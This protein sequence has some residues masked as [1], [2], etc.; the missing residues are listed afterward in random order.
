MLRV[1]LLA[2]AHGD[3]IWIEYGDPPKPRRVLIDGGPASTYERGLRNRIEKAAAE[4]SG[5][6][7]FE[8][9]II[10]HIDADHIDVPLIFLRDPGVKCTFRDI[11][12]NG[13]QQ[14]APKDDPNIFA[15][16]QGEFLASIL[17]DRAKKLPWNRET[18][19]TA[20]GAPP[21]PGKLRTVELAGGLKL[22]LL[23]P[24]ERE[25]QRLRSRWESAIRD[26]T[27]GDMEEARRRLEDRRDY[28]P[29]DLPPVFAGRTHGNDRTPANGSS[30]VVL[31]EMGG[32]AVLLTGDAHARVLAEGLR[33]LAA[34]RGVPAIRLDA[35]KLPHHGSMGN[36][37]S[38]V[39]DAVTCS[40]FLFSTNGAIFEHPDRETVDLI[41]QKAS[42]PVEFHFN[43]RS[44]TTLRFEN[45]EHGQFTSFYGDGNITLELNTE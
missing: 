1:E 23:A 42:G 4:G 38:E 2:A 45:D 28:R 13:W 11:W 3:G 43:Y 27:P 35:F 34:E 26:F 17:G 12:F 25:L 29:P 7:A 5:S 44:P 31:A 16:L 18:E 32:C 36:L 19:S 30:I 39:L 22:T 6:L 15:P 41:L 37:T 21:L 8:L 20:V 9:F 33:R 24:G 14:I 40:R 10:T